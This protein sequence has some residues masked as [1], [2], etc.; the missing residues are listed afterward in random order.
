MLELSSGFGSVS[1]SGTDDKR[2][3]G[4]AVLADATVFP[5]PLSKWFYISLPANNAMKTKIDEI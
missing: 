5:M 3:N 1:T 2:S 4:G